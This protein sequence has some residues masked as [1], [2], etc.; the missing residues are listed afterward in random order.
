MAGHFV[1][2][3]R[4]LNRSLYISPLSLGHLLGLDLYQEE[5]VGKKKQQT[6]KQKWNAKMVKSRS[7]F[8]KKIIE[9]KPQ[10]KV[11]YEIYLL[12]MY[13]LLVEKPAL[14]SQ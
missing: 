5:N 12:F 1:P 7:V 10:V 8:Y 3:K 4:G 13:I 9:M 6:N 2:W 11:A 14:L